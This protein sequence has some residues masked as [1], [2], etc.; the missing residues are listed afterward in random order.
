MDNK[1]VLI[2][3]IVAIVVFLIW[4]IYMI[5]IFSNNKLYCKHYCK[6]EWDLWKKVI[7]KLKES[8]G[9]I[10]VSSYDD[11][12]SLSSFHTNIEIDSDEYELIYWVKEGFVSVYQGT[13][14]ILC[15]Y[16]KYHSQIALEIMKD[17]IKKASDYANRETKRTIKELIDEW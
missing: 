6:K 16:D 4:T 8:K 14:C 17:K 10:Y 3:L 12:P 1:F 7:E 2:V 13:H 9:T 5:I 15:R 11:C